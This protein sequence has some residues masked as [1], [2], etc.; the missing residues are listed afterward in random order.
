[1]IAEKAA[2]VHMTSGTKRQ[3][4]RVGTRTQNRRRRGIALGWNSASSSEEG[5]SEDCLVLG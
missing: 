2:G 1:M 5:V 4:C 3:T